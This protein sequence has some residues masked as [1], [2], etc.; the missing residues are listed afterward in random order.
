MKC[1]IDIG[2]SQYGVNSDWSRKDQ[3]SRIVFGNKRLGID[4]CWSRDP[5]LTDA[6][7]ISV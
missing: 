6:R 3:K 4:D 7:I 5:S 1:D 2:L